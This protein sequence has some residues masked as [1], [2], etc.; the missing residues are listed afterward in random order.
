MIGRA[1]AW[2]A[3]LAFFLEGVEETATQA[4]EAVASLDL[5]RRDRARIAGLG[6]SASSALRLHDYLQHHPILSIPRAAEALALSGPTVR[7][8]VEY[9]A[10]LGLL[11]ET[12]GRR[13]GR[14]YVYGDYLA[15]LSEGTEP[16]RRG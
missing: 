10:G 14:L 15:I 3:W 8:S 2:E 7:K 16:L 5:F 13:R 11:K 1:G 4:M 9:L 12:T 6:R